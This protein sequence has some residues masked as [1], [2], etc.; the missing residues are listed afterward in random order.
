MTQ[1]VASNDIR[2]DIPLLQVLAE[3]GFAAR[4]SQRQNLAELLG[5][6]ID[7]ADSI[8]LARALMS[9][10]RAKVPAA[11]SMEAP[12]RQFL[13]ARAGMIKMITNCF[14]PGDTPATFNLPRAEIFSDPKEGVKPYQRFYSL[15]QSELDHRVTRLRKS[16]RAS[17]GFEGQGMVRLAALDR[18]VDD[19]LGE[20]SRRVLAVLPKLLGEQFNK[21][22]Q[23]VPGGL[24]STN[25]QEWTQPGGWLLTFYQDMRHMLLAEMDFRL[26]PARGLLD[27]L[28]TR[29]NL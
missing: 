4:S 9:L 25:P 26:L 10:D 18:I 3:L 14:E 28:D 15:I 17:L 22:S 2:S 11:A 29:E 13:N 7:L 20:H 1:A 23:N 8:A 12:Q 6:Q 16:L 21:H 24:Q 5:D 19:T 27:A